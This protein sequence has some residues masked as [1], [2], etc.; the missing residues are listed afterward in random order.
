MAKTPEGEKYLRECADEALIEYDAGNY[1]FAY[2]T[3]LS[4]FR[5]HPLTWGLNIVVVEDIA[6][7]AVAKGRDVFEQTIMNFPV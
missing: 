1:Y 7:R 3:V 6:K 5:K 4:K 2:M